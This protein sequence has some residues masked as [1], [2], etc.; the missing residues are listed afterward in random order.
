MHMVQDEW[1]LS[2]RRIF[3][4]LLLRDWFAHPAAYG[5]PH[6]APVVIGWWRMLVYHRRPRAARRHDVLRRRRRLMA[7]RA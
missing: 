1:I 5:D 4:A 7:K 2:P 6:R 3:D